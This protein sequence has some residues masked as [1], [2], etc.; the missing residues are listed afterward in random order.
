M[1]F[2][3][4]VKHQSEPYLNGHLRWPLRSVDSKECLVSFFKLCPTMFDSLFISFP[5][6]SCSSANLSQSPISS[7]RARDACEEQ[8]RRR[9]RRKKMVIFHLFD[10]DRSFLLSLCLFLLLCKLSKRIFIQKDEHAGKIGQN[11]WSYSQANLWICAFLKPRL[12]K[13]LKNLSIYFFSSKLSA[14]SGILSSKIYP[15]IIQI[16]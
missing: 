4:T 5:H 10:K 16:K 15:K 12:H 14:F 13:N 7:F 9:R 1:R 11:G 6:P 3:F 2:E 8:L